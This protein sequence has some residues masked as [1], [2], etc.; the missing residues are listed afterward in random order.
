[1]K[2]IRL[3]LQAVQVS[4]IIVTVVKRYIFIIF[5]IQSVILVNAQTQ[6]TIASACASNVKGGTALSWT[7]GQTITSTLTSPDKSVI[8][9][10]GSQE[11][12]VITSIK[13][14]TENTGTLQL[15]PNPAGDLINIRFGSPVEGDM[16]LLLLNSDGKPVRSDLIES[17]IIEKQINLQNIPSGI[18]YLR[19]I[20]GNIVNVYKV[21][22]L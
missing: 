2:R 4:V 13:E 3:F 22:K 10:Q 8:L 9:T 12:L 17:A 20:N 6:G 19:L 15:Y 21:V 18:Y 5:A 16:T 11:K 14:E 1:M 7:I